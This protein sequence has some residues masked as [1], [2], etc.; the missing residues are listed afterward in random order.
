MLDV[1]GSEKEN[2]YGPGRT[3]TSVVVF[4]TNIQN[5]FLSLGWNLI[6]EFGMALSR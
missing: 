3:S 1:D 4:T 6:C 2:M 5:V